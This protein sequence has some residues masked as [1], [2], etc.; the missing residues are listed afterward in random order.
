MLSDLAPAVEPAP[1]PDEPPSRKA[2]LEESI[3]ESYIIVR[4][5]EVTL[6]TSNRAEEKQ[7]AQARIREQWGLIE[8]YLDEY[9]R[10]TG[11]MLPADIDEIA[12][13]LR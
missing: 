3:R 8:R 12:A 11:G 4:E 10:L 7:W 2:D 5:Y 6:R 13:R 1:S 9:R